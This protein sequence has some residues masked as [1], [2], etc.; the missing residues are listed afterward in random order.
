[1]LGDQFGGELKV[2]I[3]ER[4]VAGGGRGGHASGPDGPVRS[5]KEHDYL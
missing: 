1:V 3:V 2:E 4:E 5:L